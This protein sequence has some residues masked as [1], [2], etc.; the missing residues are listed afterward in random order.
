MNNNNNLESSDEISEE[1]AEDRIGSLSDDLVGSAS[2]LFSDL[3]EFPTVT[4]TSI[5]GVNDYRQPNNNHLTSSV[6]K[7]FAVDIKTGEIRVLRPVAY[8]DKPIILVIK[9]S[10]GVHSA[11]TKVKI[12]VRDT[13]NNDPLFDHNIYHANVSETANNGYIVAKIV[14]HDADVGLNAQIIYTLFPNQDEYSDNNGLPGRLN[15]DFIINNRTGVISVNNALDYDRKNL[16]SF[17]LKAEDC[18]EP[19]RSSLTTVIINVINE[20]NKNPYFKPSTQMTEVNEHERVGSRIYKLKAEDPDLL[21]QQKLQSKHIHRIHGNNYYHNENSGLSGQ[22]EEEGLLY[23]IE[24]FVAVNKDGREVEVGSQAWREIGQFFAIDTY[25]FLTILKPLH[26]E[27]AALVTLNLSVSDTFAP[28]PQIGYGLLIVKIIDY[29]DHP[30]T[31]AAPWTITNP[32]IDFTTSEEQPVGTVVGRL[33][34]TDIDTEIDY[35]KIDPPSK[36]FSIDNQTGVIKVEK[37]LDYE[38]I[39]SE[40]LKFNVVVFDT[41]VPQLNA[42]CH[43]HVNLINLNDNKPIFLQSDYNVTIPENLEWSSFVLKVNYFIFFFRLLNS[44]SIFF[45]F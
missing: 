8:S 11:K 24:N 42:I 22:K 10:D 16:Y 1:P 41:G 27:L 2:R 18:G 44:N 31:F 5:D 6:E 26:Y 12:V 4:M 28:Y 15:N 23:R 32:R 21:V 45:Y 25:G 17:K 35:F 33:T 39:D 14:A 29:N 40:D 9:V 36:Y 30:P 34:A 19:K 38:T 43:V 7:Q 13:N 3:I 20:N 37:V